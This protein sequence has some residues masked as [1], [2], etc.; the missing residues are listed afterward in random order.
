MTDDI[1]ANFKEV[2]T[3]NL[4]LTFNSIDGTVMRRHDK[5]PRYVEFFYRTETISFKRNKED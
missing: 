5:E 1:Q 3:A 4:N 2:C